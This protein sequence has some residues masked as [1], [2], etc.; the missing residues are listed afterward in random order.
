MN[1][2]FTRISLTLCLLL[3]IAGS[4]PAQSGL[5]QSGFGYTNKSI[6]GELGLLDHQDYEWQL[7]LMK[8]DISSVLLKE[9]LPLKVTNPY[10][11]PYKLHSS[12][13][14]F[15]VQNT[16]DKVDHYYTYPLPS[17]VAGDTVSMY[18]KL[19]Y[20]EYY[21]WTGDKVWHRT[22][23][24]AENARKYITSYMYANIYDNSPPVMENW[25]CIGYE[26]AYSFP[27]SIEY[28][29]FGKQGYTASCQVYKK[30][31]NNIVHTYSV[32]EITYTKNLQV[33]ERTIYHRYVMN[34]YFE[35]PQQKE[36]YEYTYDSTGMLLAS[37]YQMGDGERVQFE[38]SYKDIDEQGNWTTQYITR[39]GIY[40]T[41]ISREIV[42]REEAERRQKEER[43]QQVALLQKVYR[44]LWGLGYFF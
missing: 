34:A 25:V 24:L 35:K 13:E 18:K 33:K 6:I 43:E 11:L 1:N 37:I 17:Q 21:Y 27:I 23:V 4:I 2:L 9:K 38:Y 44:Q 29:P 12:I 15:Y 8:G 40:Y 31:S 10:N 19:L 42:Y 3:V 14:M 28:V 7:P 32:C 36:H 20:E 5:L 16:L 30:D 26:A 22:H 39:N 41:E